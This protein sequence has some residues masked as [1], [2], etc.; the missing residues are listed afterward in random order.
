MPTQATFELSNI[1]LQ[2]QVWG[3][4]GQTPVLALHGWL[5]N[6][7]SFERL[8][9]QLNNVHL[10]ALDLAGHGQSDHRTPGTPYNIWEDVADIFAV[11]DQL[12]WKTFSLMGHSRG[13]IISTLSAGTFPDRIGGLMLIDGVLPM[14]IK[15]SDAPSQ[16]AQSINETRLFSQK[17]LRVFESLESACNARRRGRFRLSQDAASRLTARGVKTVDGGLSWSSDS[18][19]M[20]A[21]AFKLT[22]EHGL[23][24]CRAIKAK[25]A[26]V[27]AVNDS[28][29]AQHYLDLIEDVYPL[30]PVE[31]IEGTH[32]LHME[33][34]SAQVASIFNQ[35]LDQLPNVEGCHK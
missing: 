15:A 32:H 27:V 1:T 28:S 6:S 8:A 35:L 14:F 26:M 29:F 20:A 30:L 33:E 24:F 23:A 22:R 4:P 12:G 31:K 10:V 25:A 17:Q 13:A 34:E 9:E 21:S 11:A 2:A 7:A 5:D 16:L 3:E 18:R 19:L